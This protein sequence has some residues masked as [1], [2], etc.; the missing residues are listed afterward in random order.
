MKPR[1]VTF[2]I[3]GI[4]YSDDVF[5]RSIAQALT[6]LSGGINRERFEEI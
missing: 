3:G 6:E 1:A 4:I 5:K 2:D